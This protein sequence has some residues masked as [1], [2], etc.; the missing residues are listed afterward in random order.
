[1]EG[2]WRSLA[3]QDGCLKSMK[4]PKG[5]PRKTEQTNFKKIERTSRKFETLRE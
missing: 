3:R 2:E 5:G 4:S 1:M